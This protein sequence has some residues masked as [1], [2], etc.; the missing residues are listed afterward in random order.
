MHAGEFLYLTIDFS[1]SNHY[2]DS[3]G[4]DL[5]DNAGY[6]FCVSPI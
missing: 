5:P 3:H 6:L 4:K 1:V 2:T